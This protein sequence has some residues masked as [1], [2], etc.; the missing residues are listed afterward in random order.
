MSRMT[1]SNSAIVSRED[2]RDR[3][4]R[5][6]ATGDLTAERERR[7]EVAVEVEVEH[8]LEVR[9]HRAVLPA[10]RAR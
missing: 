4:D 9:D 10:R 1:A 6:D 3:L 8:V 5:V 2:L 7:V